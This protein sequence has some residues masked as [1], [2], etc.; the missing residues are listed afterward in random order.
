MYIEIRV[1]LTRVQYQ[2]YSGHSPFLHRDRTV[3]VHRR[4]LNLPALYGKSDVK[5]IDVYLKDNT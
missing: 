2:S 4:R 3:Q 1:I 5:E